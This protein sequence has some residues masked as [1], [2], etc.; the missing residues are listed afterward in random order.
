[1]VDRGGTWEEGDTTYDPGSATGSHEHRQDSDSIATLDIT[2][3]LLC[4][5]RQKK[6]SLTPEPTVLR[7]SFLQKSP[8][9]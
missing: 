3:T 6:S 7:S 8:L 9:H 4:S 2:M 5:I 1:M